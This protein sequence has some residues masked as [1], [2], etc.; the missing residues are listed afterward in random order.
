M[1]MWH[2]QLAWILGCLRSNHQLHEVE[3]KI[4]FLL[5]TIAGDSLYVSVIMYE[6]HDLMIKL[7]QLLSEQFLVQLV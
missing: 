4:G 6:K 7:D 1:M 2:N 5:G 3:G